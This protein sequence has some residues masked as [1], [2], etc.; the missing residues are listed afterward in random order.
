MRSRCGTGTWSIR[1]LY[2]AVDNRDA[3][4]HCTNTRVDRISSARVCLFWYTHISAGRACVPASTRLSQGADHGSQRPRPVASSR[5]RASAKPGQH[6]GR[7]CIC[8]LVRHVCSGPGV[9]ID[10]EAHV[11]SGGYDLRHWR[12]SRWPAA[13]FRRPVHRPWVCHC[14]IIG[15]C[16]KRD[17]SV[18]LCGCVRSHVHACAVADVSVWAS[19]HCWSW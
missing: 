6:S 14:A 15:T 17:A 4:G 2:R 11:V 9:P 10:G 1:W 7:V 13:F 12:P 19:A 8:V 5:H 18:W 16:V 3:L